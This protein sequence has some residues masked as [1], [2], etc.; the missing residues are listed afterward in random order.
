MITKVIRPLPLLLS[1][2]FCNGNT[3]AQCTST[4]WQNASSFSTDNLTG[5]YDFAIPG[6]AQTSDNVRSAA[7]SLVAIL[8]GNT[9]YLVAKNFSFSL[10]S[11]ATICGVTV[12]IESRATGLL[13]TTA[14]KDNEVKLVKNGVITGN[15]KALAGDWGSSDAFRSYGGSSDLWGTSLTAADVNSA[16]FGVAV[17]AR[18]IALISALPGA[19]IDYI[20]M[21]IDYNTILPV[22]LE[23]FNAQKNGN[24]ALIEWKTTEEEPGAVL[25]LQRKINQGEWEVLKKYQLQSI[26]AG[27]VYAVSDTLTTSSLYQ[28]R[29]QTVLTT[30][31]ISYSD[32]R[33]IRGGAETTVLM[34][35]NPATDKIT[36]NMQNISIT[37]ALG[38]HFLLPVMKKGNTSIIT[39]SGL[40]PGIYLLSDGTRTGRFVKQ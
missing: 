37:D 4:S 24:T 10:P 33:S 34:Y 15:N 21:K 19:E 16:D 1:F 8:T 25:N 11:Y 30:G 5:V 17:S 9:Y 32:V 40:S 6:N 31:K 39:I 2:L 20:R 3:S 35:P 13:L 18:I 38:R 36:V 28:Y 22:K 12:E 26:S 23:Y 27:Y 14:V 29:L 7:S